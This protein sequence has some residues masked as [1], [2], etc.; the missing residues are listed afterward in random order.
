MHIEIQ[1]EFLARAMLGLGASHLSLMTSAD[2]FKPA[3]NHRVASISALNDHLSKPHLA[4]A[5]ADAALGAL[6]AL[7]FQSA[8]MPDGMVDFLTMVRGCKSTNCTLTWGQY[9]AYLH[10]S[11]G[12][13]VASHQTFNFG[14]SVFKP[15]A[16]DAFVETARQIIKGDGDSDGDDP[17]NCMY[18]AFAEDFCP[19][20][21]RLKP[22][23]HSAA[24][25]TYLA[26]MTRIATLAVTD[27]VTSEAT[28]FLW[29][30]VNT[31][32]F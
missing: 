24:E 1:Y 20:L 19:S 5:D 30:C 6:L 16:A 29:H 21:E 8:Y 7:T 32:V 22:L 11:A 18:N 4:K 23:C 28:P 3:L 31:Y 27:P 12:V 17:G 15:G 26:I 9:L 2:H 25:L 10:I 14:K 13:L